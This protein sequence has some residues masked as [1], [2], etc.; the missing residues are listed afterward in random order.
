MLVIEDLP[1]ALV[2]YKFQLNI[3]TAYKIDLSIAAS[4]SACAFVHGRV[5]VREK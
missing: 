5:L 1:L 4:L 2:P 3:P